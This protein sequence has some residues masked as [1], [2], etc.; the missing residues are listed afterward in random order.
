MQIL[1]ASSQTLLN[2]STCC[3][4]C[5]ALKKALTLK[6][7]HKLL[8]AELG[9]ARDSISLYAKQ[10]LE[11]DSVILDQKSI[12]NEKDTIITNKTQ[13]ISERDNQI[14]DLNHNI[15]VFKRQRNYAIGGSGGLLILTILLLL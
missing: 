4:P 6:E 7:D 14:K 8:K 2:D 12:I 1:P 10:G 3:V 9:V 13:I 5:A 15:G 11:K